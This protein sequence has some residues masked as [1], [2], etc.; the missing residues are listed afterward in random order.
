MDAVLFDFDFT[1]GDSSKGILEC[2]RYA[3][4]SCGLPVPENEA[5]L[6]TIGMSLKDTFAVLSPGADPERLK[7]FYVERADQV[8]EGATWMY[9]GVP[10][11]MS[12]LRDRGYKLGIVTTKFRY[13]IE[14]ILKRDGL[15]HL[16]DVV[17]GFEDVGEPKPDPEALETAVR[18]LQCDRESAVYVGD[19]VVDAKAA[20]SAGIKFI[21]VSTGTTSKDD[22]SKHGALAVVDNLMHLLDILPKQDG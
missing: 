8:I 2:M 15:S 16:V 20:A 4:E 22:L 21:G 18:R 7:A 11:L 6:A 19:S 1:L 17:V 12:A 3:L 14:G 9:D 13:R 5:I 10:E